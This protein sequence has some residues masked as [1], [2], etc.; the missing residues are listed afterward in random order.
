MQ[1]IKIDT[2]T[3]ANSIHIKSTTSQSPDQLTMTVNKIMIRTPSH[4]PN[5]IEITIKLD[6]HQKHFEGTNCPTMRNE[7]PTVKV[8]KQNKSTFEL[9]TV[10][11]RRDFA[12][13]FEK[14]PASSRSVVPNRTLTGNILGEF[15]FLFSVASS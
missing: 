13:R 15:F 12:G 9:R 5:A 10:R 4:E 6:K 7:T 1:V 2:N 11:T 8:E 3:G 14:L